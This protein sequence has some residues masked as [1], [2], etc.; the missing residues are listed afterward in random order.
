M[1]Q[2]YYSPQIQRFLVCAIFHEALARGIPMTV[3]VNQ[4]L[5]SALTDTEGWRK[6]QEAGHA[7]EPHKQ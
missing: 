1:K 4:V 3:L 2:R 5:A 7:L 6:A